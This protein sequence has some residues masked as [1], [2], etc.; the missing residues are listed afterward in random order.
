MKNKLTVI[1]KAIEETPWDEWLIDNDRYLKAGCLVAVIVCAVYFAAFV[2]YG[3][4][5]N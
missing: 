5:G 1:Q 2:F 4:I 3:I